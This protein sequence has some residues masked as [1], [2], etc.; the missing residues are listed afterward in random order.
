MNVQ[1]T[2]K[3][4]AVGLVRRLRERGHKA[5][6]AGG[7]VR[8]MIMGVESADY[9]IATGARPEEIMGLF[10]RTLPVGVQFGVVV[11]MA[12]GFQF[13]VAT[14][15]TEGAYSD[16]R[17]PDSVSFAGP[18]EDARRRDFTI[19]GMFYDPL[20]DELIDLVGGQRD[21][22]QR[23]VRTI[24]DPGERFGED[25]LR[26]IRVVRFASRF[27]YGIDEPAAAVVKERA[28]KIHVVSWERI[29]EELQK[30]LLDDNRKRGL[31]LLD[32]LALLAEILPEVS[33]MK[34]V[35]QPENFHPEGDVFI[36]T[37]LSVS[38]L[39]NP[40]WVLAMGTLLHDV[41]K[42]VTIEERDGRIRYPLHESMG[43]EMAGKICDRLKT[44]RE[45]KGK[46]KWLVKKHLAF[47]DARNMRLSKLKRLLSHEDYPLL[48][49]VS[50]VDAL[51]S[52]GDLADCDFCQQMREQF[53]EEELKPLR[54]LTGE[55]LIALGLIPGPI[56]SKVLTRVYDEQLEGEIRSKEEALDRARELTQG[57]RA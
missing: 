42:P 43:A 3:E 48:A 8:D 22:E 6:F 36:H 53:R 7:C 52:T 15:R 41:A 11:V 56:F 14:F 47:K 38:Y 9:D 26:M 29:R 30:I 31:Q 44:S 55:D 37:L 25:Y 39:K 21:I 50:R 23:I 54:F 33:A 49:E 2:K 28:Q 51:A 13:E 12:G 5:L 19:N 46:I 18:E 45:E 1:G 32:E 27:G 40:S 16:G 24:G 10:E 17:H 57:A 20:D 34:G 4:I 35:E